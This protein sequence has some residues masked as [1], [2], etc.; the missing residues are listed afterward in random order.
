MAV[1]LL[2]F[3][4]TSAYENWKDAQIV[5]ITQCELE[6]GVVSVDPYAQTGPGTAVEHP[7]ATTV[8]IYFASDDIPV[9]GIHTYDI[10]YVEYDLIT[11]TFSMA[12]DIDLICT[13]PIN[14]TGQDQD[15]CVTPDGQH[16]FFL[17]TGSGAHDHE[18]YMAEKDVSG[19]WANP[20][21]LPDTLNAGYD[22][23]T[24]CYF[25]GKLYF[26][27]N[28]R[29]EVGTSWDIW[30][31]DAD[32]EAETFTNFTRLVFPPPW[33]STWAE[34]DPFITADGRYMYF[35]APR[36]LGEYQDI[37][38]SEWNGFEWGYPTK[39]DT[40]VNGSDND[41]SPSLTAAGHIL[42]FSK[43][44]NRGT[45]QATVKTFYA[46]HDLALFDLIAED[47]PNDQGGKIHLQWDAHPLDAYPNTDITHY[48]AWRRIDKLV[49]FTEDV[50]DA[51]GDL[52]IPV[53]FEGKAVRHSPLGDGF[54]WEWL[55]NVPARGI[56]TYALLV[57]SLY[58]SMGTDPGWQCFMVTAHTE[59]PY[60]YYDSDVACGYSVDNLPPFAP[61][62]FQNTPIDIVDWDDNLEEDMFGYAVYGR[63]EFEGDYE[64]LEIVNVSEY[65]IKPAISSGYHWFGVS[66]LDVHG[67]MSDIA[68]VLGYPTPADDTPIVTRLG[69]NFPNPFNPTTTFRFD[70]PRAV[71]VKLCVY[72]VKGDLVST[73]FD[74]HMTR[75]RKEVS[76]TAKD[77][78]G[79][80]VS[81][82]IYFYR[83]VAGDFVQTK[84]MVLLR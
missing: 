23:H 28:D 6:S 81:S 2:A 36:A 12:R 50:I 69:Q 66:A 25:G 45:P 30:Y 64:L 65:D 75:G 59:M 63:K 72:N 58:D 47:V 48:S 20:H 43:T 41:G 5:P 78:S 21:R 38:Y 54:A 27:A 18:I 39:A 84:K 37:Y 22:E 60:E 52:N 51:S 74:R 7:D 14:T 9:V 62:G 70:L 57:E 32:L 33:D 8:F 1:L 35:S 76:W 77:N 55:A 56:D 71:H 31:C 19:K 44:L 73:I 42:F 61:T 79:R 3:G 82:G 29:D 16:F 83:L 11:K 4:V 46:E 67:N 40:T 53:D 49:A 17:R 68:P 13:D 15:P 24:G 34:L 26:S 80:A 10:Y